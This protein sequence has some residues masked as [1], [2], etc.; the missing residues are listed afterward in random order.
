MSAPTTHGSDPAWV[1]V[2]AETTGLSPREHRIVELAVVVLDERGTPLGEASTLVDPG[3]DLGSTEAHGIRP[4]HLAGAPRFG[5]IAGWLQQWLAGKVVVGHNLL[6]TTA[7][8]DEEYRRVGISMPHVPVICTMTH[9]PRYLPSLPGR[10]LEQCCAAAGIPLPEQ[11]S[12]L[13]RARAAAALFARFLNH[14]ETVPSPWVDNLA[15]ARKLSWPR[16]PVR[17]FPLVNRPVEAA[18]VK[19]KPLWQAPAKGTATAT[20]RPAQGSAAVR[21]VPRATPPGPAGAAGSARP[22]TPAGQARPTA[23]ATSGERTPAAATPSSATPSS[24]TPGEVGPAAAAPEAAA[25]ATA[26]KPKPSPRPRP[27]PRPAKTG[28][29]SAPAAREPAAREPGPAEATAREAGRAEAATPAPAASGPTTD[30][31]QPETREH[32]AELVDQAPR[33]PGESDT[34]ATY[35]GALDSAVSD[36]ILSFTEAIH[37]KDLAAALAIFEAEQAEAHR[38][39]LRTLAATAWGDHQLTEAERTDLLAVGKLLEVSEDEVDE[40][41]A[42][43]MPHRTGRSQGGYAAIGASGSASVNA[44]QDP[45]VAAWYPDPY[46]ESRLRWWDGTVWTGHLHD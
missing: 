13:N 11:R 1:V 23:P 44:A 32:V 10:T 9:A 30:A 21:P 46:G 8:L 41:I 29:A 35:L 6:F 3:P 34:V 40:A 31:A 20:V 7:F 42:D 15:K 33:Q 22:A 2:D 37:L 26:V 18:P 27:S 16:T 45:A 24:A 39:Y 19:A 12:A 4:E 28:K 17:D 14:R 43:T 38:T 25:E 5:S 36:R